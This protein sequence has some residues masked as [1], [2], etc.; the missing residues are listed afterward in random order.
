[1]PSL[2]PIPEER[3]ASSQ[4]YQLHWNRMEVSIQPPDR[5]TR[6]P[7]MVWLLV[8]TALAAVL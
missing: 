4:L 8:G 3:A 1:M 6:A 5:K 7:R 2:P